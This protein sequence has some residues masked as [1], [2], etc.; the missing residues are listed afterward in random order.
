MTSNERS[1]AE[2][3]RVIGRLLVVVTYVSVACIL[4]GVLLMASQGVSPLDPAPPFDL[5]TIPADIVA[6][7][8]TGF[9]W[10]GILLVLATPI[11]RVAVAGWGYARRGDR[12]FLAISIA[13]LV[14]IAI[15]IV[16]ALVAEA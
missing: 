4:V 12:R 6:L 13:V 16:T 1:T 14:V 5:S 11:S 3:E 15:G 9:L 10:L 8:P 7:R 2:L